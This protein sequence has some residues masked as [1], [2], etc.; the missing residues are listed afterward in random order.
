M[1]GANLGS[2]VQDRVDAYRDNPAA[3]QQRYMQSQELIDLL[4]LQ[5][6][7]STQQNF[8]RDMQL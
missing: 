6:M 5:K 4:A 2:D 8:A 7:K 1:I 3:L